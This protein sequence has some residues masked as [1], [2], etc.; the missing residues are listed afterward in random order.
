MPEPWA[1]ARA[2]LAIATRHGADEKTLAE[3]RAAYR[4]AHQSAVV[5]RAIEKVAAAAPVLTA[6]QRARLAEL[7]CSTE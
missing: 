3:L 7:L 6:A 5:D 1:Q 4:V 2:K